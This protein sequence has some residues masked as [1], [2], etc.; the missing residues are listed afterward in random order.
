MPKCTDRDER[1]MLDVYGEL[2]TGARAAWEDHLK[3]CADCRRE[4]DELTKLLAQTRQV[5]EPPPLTM[6]DSAAVVR[7][8]QCRLAGGC[9]AGWR[10]GSGNRK[11][12][13]WIPAFATAAVLFL[14]V[15]FVG[16]ERPGTVE[17][18]PAAGRIDIS[19]KLPQNDEE[20]IKNMDLLKNFTTLEK[21]SQVVDDSTGRSPSG[22]NDQGTQGDIR[23]V[24]DERSA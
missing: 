3:D 6:R 2:D 9:L 12:G 19:Q 14:V 18:Q 8:V 24:H 23:Y 13:L 22:T 16:Y 4:K 1:V 10:R 7:H 17:Q 15:L 20:I 21:L 5:M 11:R